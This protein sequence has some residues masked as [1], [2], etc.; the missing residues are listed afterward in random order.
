MLKKPGPNHAFNQETSEDAEHDALV[1]EAQHRAL[2]KMTS[3]GAPRAAPIPGMSAPM[4]AVHPPTPAAPVSVMPKLAMPAAPSATVA[5]P[6]MPGAPAK[7][8]FFPGL[9]SALRKPKIGI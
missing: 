1:A 5:A 7:G 3:A 6:S 9:M 2:Q 4:P 8:Q